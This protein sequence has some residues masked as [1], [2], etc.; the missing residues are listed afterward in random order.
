MEI[1]GSYEYNSKE[2][3]GHGAFAVVF[4]GRHREAH[5]PVAIKSITK[6][7][8]AKSQ[9]LLGK[10]IKILQELS[11]LKHKNVV[12]LLACTEK[13]QN[14]FLVM[15]ISPMISAST[16]TP[17]MAISSCFIV[18]GVIDESKDCWP[19]GPF[20]DT[21]EDDLTTSPSPSTIVEPSKF[22]VK[23][24]DNV[25][26]QQQLPQ[27]RTI[28]ERFY[29]QS[30]QVVVA[31]IQLYHVAGPFGKGPLICSSSSYVSSYSSSYP[32]IP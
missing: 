22:L 32:S 12:K 8:L 4:K 15:E 30:L 17:M 1:V 6:K 31:Q 10:E 20:S 3:I 13:D 2:I 18:S 26:C 7:S 9:S 21:V 11:A 25:A 27:T 16:V 5:Y 23:L 28:L 14:V 29:V 19:A 24:F